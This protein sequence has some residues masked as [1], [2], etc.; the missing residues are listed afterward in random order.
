MPDLKWSCVCQGGRRRE[1]HEIKFK[2]VSVNGFKGI[3][4]RSGTNR[5]S[6][7]GRPDLIEI[8]FGSAHNFVEFLHG[9]GVDQVSSYYYDPGIAFLEE[10]SSGRNAAKPEDHEG[11]VESTRSFAK[12]L[13]DVGGSCLVVKAMGSYRGEAPVTEAKIKTV[14]ECWDKVGKMTNEYGVKTAMHLNCLCAIH[15][16]DDIEKLL[17]LTTPDLV[18]LALDTAEQTIA[19]IDAV[20]LYEKHY[21]RVSHIY[22]V[23]ALAADTLGEYKTAVG[24]GADGGPGFTGGDKRIAQ[25]YGAMGTPGGL[26]NFPAL[27]KSVR[28]HNYGGWLV[29]ENRQLPNSAHGCMLNGYYIKK[30][31]PGLQ[32]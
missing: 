25:W 3:E 16:I 26:V 30:V 15:T 2:Q 1:M 22:C 31:V 10:S 7:T 11:I 4:L 21:A 24:G 13:R 18:G 28:Q 14:A 9:C 29:A 6:P 32:G 23:D 19:G 5:F 20:A 12:F 27:I 8:N 17:S